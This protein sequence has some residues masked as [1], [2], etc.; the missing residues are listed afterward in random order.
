M[1]QIS[2]KKTVVTTVSNLYE[3]AS[4]CPVKAEQK[5][6]NG[7]DQTPTLV[8]KG[9]QGSRPVIVTPEFWNYIKAKNPF[10]EM[11][12]K[13][14]ASIFAYREEKDGL[15]LDIIEQAFE[16][17]N[18]LFSDYSNHMMFALNGDPISLTYHFDYIGTILSNQYLDLDKA[19]EYL[20][21]HPW[22]TNKNDIEVQDIPY[23]NRDEEDG[24]TRFIDLYVRLDD[25]AYKKLYEDCLSEKYPSVAM[26]DALNGSFWSKQD[27]LGLHSFLN[28]RGKEALALHKKEAPKK[29]KASAK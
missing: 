7:K 26:K 19:V 25:K 8:G 3:L 2:S 29:T 22:T 20:S 9:P 21:K 4:D 16:D 1:K 24:K 28:A 10:H 5:V 6:V 23:Y 11:D 13:I 27:L 12:S 14:T 17:G 15:T 18:I